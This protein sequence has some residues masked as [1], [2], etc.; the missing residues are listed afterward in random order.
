MIYL[1]TVFALLDQKL[2][3]FCGKFKKI[4]TLCI[5]CELWLIC[6]NDRRILEGLTNMLTWT[7][8]GS[9]TLV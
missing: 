3:Q 1:S 4:A 8:F 5:F 9:L 7:L 6:I 2:Q